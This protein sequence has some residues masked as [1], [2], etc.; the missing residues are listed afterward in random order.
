MSFL[1]NT[2]NLYVPEDAPFA[3]TSFN[4]VPEF[5][6]NLLAFKVPSG[7]ILLP[8]FTITLELGVNKLLLVITFVA[9]GSN[10]KLGQ[11]LSE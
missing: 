8:V 10:N 5:A 9:C 3:S 7:E 2:E 11:E 1:A 4:D 6:V